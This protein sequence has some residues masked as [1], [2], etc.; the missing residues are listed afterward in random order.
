MRASKM[1]YG[2]R[3]PRFR[4]FLLAAGITSWLATVA[5]ALRGLPHTGMNWPDWMLAALS[6]GGLV[7]MTAGSIGAIVIAHRPRN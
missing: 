4:W 1:D 5:G 3:F 2:Q 6:L 7:A